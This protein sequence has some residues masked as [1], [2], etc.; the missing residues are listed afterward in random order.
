MDPVSIGHTRLKFDMAKDHNN[1]IGHSVTIR[2]ELIPN[3]KPVSN[4]DG[5]PFES[6]F[7]WVIA[8][9]NCVHCTISL[10]GGINGHSL[11]LL[12]IIKLWWN[13]PGSMQMVDCMTQC[14]NLFPHIERLNYSRRS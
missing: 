5:L 7:D 12:W 9:P 6:V 3:L 14:D 1:I 2:W 8:G 13:L 11:T 10:S 4:W